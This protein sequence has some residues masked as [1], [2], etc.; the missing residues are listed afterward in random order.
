[1]Q[2]YEV[3]IT[4]HAKESLRNIALY[5][6]N[7]LHAPKAAEN[8]MAVIRREM[9]SLSLMP[10]RIPLAPEEPWRSYGIHRFRVRNF[11]V[12]F[13]INDIDHRV[14]ITDV[15]FVGRNQREQLEIMPFG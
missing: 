6:L 2:K 3:R 9:E 1:M 7:E 15:I 4:S 5:I 14:L 12:Y 8:T 10:S 13:W 11:Y